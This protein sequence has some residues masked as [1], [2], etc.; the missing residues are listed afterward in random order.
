MDGKG[1]EHKKRKTAAATETSFESSVAR[2]GQIVEQ[3]ESG[4]HPLEKSLELFEEGIRLA[5]ASQ[6]TLDDAERR[7]EQLLT[8][9]ENGNPVVRELPN[10]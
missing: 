9:D 7:V 1:P 10:D 6:A 4:E 2:L 8:V 5:R 3:L